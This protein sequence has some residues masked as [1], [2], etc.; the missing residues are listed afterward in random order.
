MVGQSEAAVLLDELKAYLRL[1]G[2]EEDGLLTWL[3]RAAT[4]AVEA[5]LGWVLVVRDVEERRLVRD[6][7]VR[8]GVAP[9]YVLTEVVTAAGEAVAAR[10]CGTGL[11]VDGVADGVELTLRYRAGMSPDWNGLPEP[12]RLAVMRAAAH[13]H[14]HRDAADDAGLPPAVG[15]LIAPWRAR[16]VL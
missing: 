6:G 9:L 8:M 16:R 10:P 15:Q 11:L 14:A 12:V 2:P 3:L 4:A 7:G 5:S 1:D 13:F